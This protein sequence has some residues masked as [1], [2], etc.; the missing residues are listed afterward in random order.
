MN[1]GSTPLRLALATLALAAAGC[2]TTGDPRRGGLFGWSE[3]QAQQRQRSLQQAQ[4]EAQQQAAL[5]TQRG[6]ALQGQQAR[7]SAEGSQLRSELDRLLAENGKLEQQLRDLMQRRQLGENE[8]RRLGK[9]LAD[10]QQLRAGARAAARP[11]AAPGAPTPMQAQAVNEQNGRLHR[12]V[13]LLLQ[14]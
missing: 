11:G 14:P 2:A 6:A 12:E 3:E 10:N 1:T 13:M 5:E 4:T 9:L 7:L 8:A